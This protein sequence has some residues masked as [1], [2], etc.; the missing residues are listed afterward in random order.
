MP[1]P[2]RKLN[3]WEKEVLLDL[4]DG[5]AELPATRIANDYE[6]KARS[7][8]VEANAGRRFRVTVEEITDES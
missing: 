8:I 6:L 1:E 3:H 4:R 7:L 2:K 5:L